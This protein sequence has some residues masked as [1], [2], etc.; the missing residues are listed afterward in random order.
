MT[1]SNQPIGF[2]DQSNA[3]V[4]SNWDWMKSRLEESKTATALQHLDDWMA[5]Q[6]D[7][8]ES[9]YKSFVTEDSLKRVAGLLVKSTRR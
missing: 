8:L 2:E 9:S 6:L 5:V 4:S 1:Y 7:Q 3:Q